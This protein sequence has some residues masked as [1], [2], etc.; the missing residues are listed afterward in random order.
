M[1]M[2]EY[3]NRKL[4]VVDTI[5]IYPQISGI[6]IENRSSL[7]DDL[8]EGDSVKLLSEFIQRHL[9]AA[10]IENSGFKNAAFLDL[11]LKTRLFLKQFNLNKD[12]SLDLLVPPDGYT[13]QSDS[14]PIDF[15]LFLQNIHTYDDSNY[16]Y[17]P[18]GYSANSS[19]S[20]KCDFEYVIWD[21]MKGKI[22][23]CGKG[24][25]NQSALFGTGKGTWENVVNDMAGFIFSHT[26]FEF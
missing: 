8:G 3:N 6:L 4:P 13:F 11:N 22:V 24:T 5:F 1:V 10:I 14:F 19:R 7:E 20:L 18:S 16:S 26:P 21:N 15:I 17:N 2:P 9:P 23:S 12:L 25:S